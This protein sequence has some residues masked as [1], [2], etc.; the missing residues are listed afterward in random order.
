MSTEVKKDH[1]YLHFA[2]TLAIMLLFRF[3]PPI[4]SITPYGMAI[5]GIFIGMIYGWSV[6][7][8]NLIWTSLLGLF[9]LALTDYGT[10]GNALAAAFGNESVMLMLLGMF[11]HILKDLRCHIL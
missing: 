5:I 9:A 2:I 6:D 7:A 4:G 3:I 11:F 1:K 8:G 10:A